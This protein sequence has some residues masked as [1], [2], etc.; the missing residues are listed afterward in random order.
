MRGHSRHRTPLFESHSEG[1]QPHCRGSEDR[2]W[3]WSLQQR[4]GQVQTLGLASVPQEHVSSIQGKTVRTPH[5]FGITG[6]VFWGPVPTKKG[7]SCRKCSAHDLF[8][9]RRVGRPRKHSRPI[10]F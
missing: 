2:A 1:L 7:S 9:G 6:R 10:F 4:W 3:P 8:W 5:S